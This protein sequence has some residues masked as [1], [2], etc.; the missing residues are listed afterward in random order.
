MFTTARPKLEGVIILSDE[1]A[2]VPLVQLIENALAAGIH[3]LSPVALN[4]LAEGIHLA[5]VSE[6]QDRLVMTGTRFLFSRCIQ[7]LLRIISASEFG[8]I[9]D[10]RFLLGIGRV[11]YLNDLLKFGA[12]HFQIAFEIARRLFVEYRVL[13]ERKSA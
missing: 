10:M 3:V 9:H 8:I 13:P 2:S 6:K 7:D 1:T 11:P 5:A 4:T 12:P